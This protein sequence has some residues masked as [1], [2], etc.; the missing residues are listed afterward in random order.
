MPDILSPVKPPAMNAGVAPSSALQNRYDDATASGDVS[1]VKAIAPI[2][3]GT[4]L[5][6]AI[7]QSSKFMESKLAPAIA[8]TAAAA[9]KGGI[10]TADGRLAAD[11]AARKAIAGWKGLQPD[12][13]FWTGVS[14]SLMGVPDP[15]KG[16]TQGAIE[17]QI[18]YDV[19][20]NSAEVSYAQNNPSSPFMVVDP[21]T[22]QPMSKQEYQERKFNLY[23]DPATNPFQQAVGEV[24]KKNSLAFNDTAAKTNQSAAAYVPIAEGAK[25]AEAL[26]TDISSKYNLD[27]KTL[28]ELAGLTSKVSQKENSIS[29][30]FNILNSGSS[31]GSKK[32]ALDKLAALTGNLGFDG[33]LGVGAKGQVTDSTGKTIGTQDLA[34]RVQD[35]MKKNSL[36]SQ[37]SQAKD[38]LVK[39]AVYQ[40]LPSAELKAKLLQAINLNEAN[41]VRMNE[42]KSSPTGEL[43]FLTTSI[44]HKMGDPF[45]VGI[46]STIFDQANA[47]KALAWADYFA[48]ESAKFSKNK[49]PVAGQLEAAFARSPIMQEINDT[50][51]KR[52]DE[53]Q[54]R[55]YPESPIPSPVGTTITGTELAPVEKTATPKARSV[56]APAEAPKLNH[57]DAFLKSRGG[58]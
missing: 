32:E 29:D 58:K 40:S 16:I 18:Q 45:Q 3:V 31:T 38:D 41:H 2:A 49:P 52:M 30:S 47:T 25:Q 34:Q 13:S 26:L 24:F 57:A 43:P 6:P 20:G 8:I 23:K 37:Y 1:A 46:I 51:A 10:D 22:G 36:S 28:N 4:T 9:N 19:N 5:A 35:Y 56:K 27:N 53:V 39:S 50:F 55:K 7:D 48:K 44:P 12:T 11:A 33:V 14:R 17:T 54:S 21:A 15:W 42:L